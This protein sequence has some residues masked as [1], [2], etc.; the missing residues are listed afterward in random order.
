LCFFT[1]SSPRP[2]LRRFY[3]VEISLTGIRGVGETLAFAVETQWVQR[4]GHGVVAGFYVSQSEKQRELA[5]L[6]SR[7]QHRV[8][9]HPQDY[10]L[11]PGRRPTLV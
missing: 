1:D 6:V 7:L 9:R 2:Q 5:G 11:E 4:A 10:L 8:V 3:Q